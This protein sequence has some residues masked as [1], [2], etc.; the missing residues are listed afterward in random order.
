MDPPL[1][2]ECG[3]IRCFASLIHARSPLPATSVDYRLRRGDYLRRSLKTKT[4]TMINTIVP[5][6]MYM[7]GSASVVG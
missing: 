4:M 7:A 5:T 1:G 2:V 3:L 6:P